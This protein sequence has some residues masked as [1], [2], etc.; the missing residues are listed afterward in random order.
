MALGLTRKETVERIEDSDKTTSEPLRRRRGFA[1]ERRGRVQCNMLLRVSEEFE[2]DSHELDNVQDNGEYRYYL[3]RIRERYEDCT[4]DLSSERLGYSVCDDRGQFAITTTGGAPYYG[5]TSP[6]GIAATT[7]FVYTYARDGERMLRYDLAKGT[8][9]IYFADT[10]KIKIADRYGI[11]ALDDGTV[12]ITC[13]SPS[14]ND[15]DD[16]PQCGLLKYDPVKDEVLT[17][18]R[19]VGSTPT[20]LVIIDGLIYIADIDGGIYRYD[21]DTETLDQLTSGHKPFRFAITESYLWV[22]L[23]ESSLHRC[24]IATNRTLNCEDV[25]VAVADAG[26]IAGRV[27]DAGVL[28]FTED[29]SSIIVYDAA[30]DSLTT[31][32]TGSKLS[33]SSGP[34]NGREVFAVATGNTVYYVHA[35]EETSL[36]RL[37]VSRDIHTAALDDADKQI[38]GDYAVMATWFTCN[39]LI[40]PARE[41][42]LTFADMLDMTEERSCDRGGVGFQVTYSLTFFNVTDATQYAH[43]AAQRDCAT[44]DVPDKICGAVKD[45]PP[46]L[47]EYDKK[48]AMLDVLGNSIANTELVFIVLILVTAALL[49]CIGSAGIFQQHTPGILVSKTTT[50]KR[51]PLSYASGDG[52]PSPPESIVVVEDTKAMALRL[53]DLEEEI[54]QLRQQQQPQRKFSTATDMTQTTQFFENHRVMQ[55]KSNISSAL[56]LDDDHRHFDEEGGDLV[57]PADDDELPDELPFTE[58]V[59]EPLERYL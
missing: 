12:Y 3:A 56:T 47:C 17:V 59:V 34:A 40:L 48:D 18:I 49:T 13:G 36:G 37:E 9:R 58:G 4:N 11:A 28:I 1:K 19:E 7:D 52:I 41:V 14:T 43:A 38:L 44:L 29:Q 32:A 22:L 24:T 45:N 30:T 6:F 31:V 25:S 39:E 50:G 26:D 23:E 35:A 55:T 46:Y 42:P 53:A 33:T 20:D 2:F 10:S 15:D 57:Y 5:L 21:P 51:R 27:N 54:R 8:M 16:K